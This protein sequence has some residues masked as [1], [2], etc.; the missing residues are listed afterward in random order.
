MIVVGRLDGT[1]EFYDAKT[2]KVAAP[3]A[4]VLAY[5]E[6]RGVQR[7]VTNRLRLVGSNLFN[8]AE[9]RTSNSNLTGRII[10]GDSEKPNEAAAE[11]EAAAD[12]QP[13]PYEIWVKGNVGE[14][15]KIK[16]HVDALPQVVET[17]G[18]TNVAI[19]LPANIWGALNPM[20]DS[21]EFD[22]E[23][24]AGDTIVLDLQ[25]K[26]F[27]SKANAVLTLLDDSAKVIASN[28]DYDGID[29]LLAH[30]F[31]EDGRYTVRVSELTLA[32]SDD[33]F[34]RLSLG[35]LPYV[36]GCFPLSVAVGKE[37]EVSLI[38]FN[39][40]ENATVKVAPE[41]AGDTDLSL[42]VETFRTRKAF[43]VVASDLPEN[44]EAE[45]NDKAAQATALT[46]PGAIGGR[47]W[48]MT[49]PVDTDFYR[50]E[51]RKGEAWVIETQAA[52]KGS[53][54]DTRIDVLFADGKPIE[55]VVLQGV[56]DSMINFRPINSEQSGA[57]VDNW[58]EMELNQYLYL[59][60]EVVRLFRMPQ[61]PDSE[62]VFYTLGGKRRPY[63]DTTA[64]A[65]ALEEPCYIVEAHPPGAKLV[66]TG[67]PSFSVFYSNDD[68]AARKAGT[69]SR[70]YF[71]APKDASYLVR[72]MDTRSEQGE[73][74]AY[75]LVVR[76]PKPSFE[77]TLAPQNVSVAAGSGQQFTLTAERIDGFDGAITV[78][79]TDLPK[80]FT[81][82]TPLV[83]EAGHSE[84]KGTLNAALDASKPEGSNASMARVLARA[85]IDGVSVTNEM[86]NFGAVKLGGQPKL[87]VMFEPYP[88]DGVTNAPAPY[89]LTIAP[90]QTIPAMLRIKRN[91]H[92]DLVTFTVENL[93]HGVIVD[94]IGLNGV[95]IPKGE[96]Q[97]DIFLSAQRW[98]PETD[99][100]C[101]AIEGQAGKQTSVPLLLRVR[102]D[103]AKVASRP[104]VTSAVGGD[105]P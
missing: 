17:N 56:R 1:L 60:G 69:D 37:T 29:P 91:G 8:L 51:A 47:I 67:L 7:G 42:D 45:P 28:N 88:A 39:L 3:P 32:G 9:L 33:H 97:R 66:E 6:P 103:G 31:K 93:P 71:T 53:P 43:K 94:N 104:A 21:D 14:S 11:I 12:L 46:V 64:L 40:P 18:Q 85:D 105:K 38:G 52:R 19:Q 13:G 68:D 22:F 99:R 95:L 5:A 102:K 86:K 2:G 34:Y 65:H 23:A 62:M 79:I 10:A 84:A 78:D 96:N 27:G 50:F 58:E 57:R 83:I 55:R 81:A 26:G 73:R 30:T 63:F 25:A 80:G 35:Q 90:G 75:R 77:V 59:N 36:T 24:R 89:E 54:V 76:K 44:V 49:A 20:G 41:K 87:F 82:S 72:V 61:G 98:V 4:P 92:E 100:W 16:L 70:L 74:F 48:S 15:G 101:Y